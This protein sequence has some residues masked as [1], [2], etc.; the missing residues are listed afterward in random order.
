MQTIFAAIFGRSINVDVPIIFRD[1]IL[2]L[3]LPRAEDS[4]G[5]RLYPSCR[6]SSSDLFPEQGAER[7]ADKTIK[8]TACL[9]GI[10][11]VHID[12]A[13]FFDS[14]FNCIRSNLVKTDTTVIGRINA[15]QFCN[16]PGD[17]LPFPVR[18]GGKQNFIGALRSSLQ[19]FFYRRFPLDEDVLGGEIVLY[20]NGQA[21]FGQVDNMSDACLYDVFAA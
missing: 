19:F 6:K 15:Q 17:R 14:S 4:K 2:D 5:Y 9:L 10:Y 13:W 7:V 12:G 18:V 3:F 21:A 1:K 11:P 16:M 8:H 20:I